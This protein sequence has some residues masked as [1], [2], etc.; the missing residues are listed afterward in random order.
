[1]PA[2]T[3]LHADADSDGK[4]MAV[5]QRPLCGAGNAELSR[6]VR[7]WSNDKKLQVFDSGLQ[8]TEQ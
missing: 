5:F 8:G 4:S 2:S 7:R 3:F 6:Q 1:M